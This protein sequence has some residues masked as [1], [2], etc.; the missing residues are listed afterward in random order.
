ME[1]KL[2]PTC[3]E[4]KPVSEF[5]KN[6]RKKDGYDRQCKDCTNARMRKAYAENPEIKISYSRQYRLDHPEWSKNYQR[7]WHQQH[8]DER[9]E[10]YK[11]LGTDPEVRK[12]RRNYTRVSEQKR[13]A[14]KA[15]GEVDKITTVEL[16]SL[17]N[18]YENK[19]WICSIELTEEILHW[20]HYKPLSVGGPHNLDNLRPA[21]NMCNIRKSNLWPITEELLESIRSAVRVSRVQKEVNLY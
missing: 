13:R 10:K 4:T 3:G 11:E 5:P 15:N 16:A 20:D 14:I 8:A 9:Y 1:N 7:E 18:K 17:L 12:R 21:C 6:K 2:C 19:C